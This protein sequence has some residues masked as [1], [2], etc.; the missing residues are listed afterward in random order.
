[1]AISFVLVPLIGSLLISHAALRLASAVPALSPSSFESSASPRDCAD[2]RWYRSRVL[3]HFC[4]P[5]VFLCVH[6]A[7]RMWL[8]EQ[9]W[10]DHCFQSPLCGRTFGLRSR[11]ER[12]LISLL[13][14]S[15]SLSLSYPPFLPLPV[16]HTVTQILKYSFSS[17]F[18]H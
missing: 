4:L 1:M 7:C 8:A 3:A 15:P 2:Q 11:K 14:P 6:G 5:C 12:A 17:S 16:L 13:F 9:S 10:R 18:T